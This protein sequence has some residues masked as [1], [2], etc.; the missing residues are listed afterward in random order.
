MRPGRLSRTLQGA[1]ACLIYGFLYIPLIVLMVY[2]F[3]KSKYVVFWRGFSFQ[4]YEKLLTN[5][6]LVSAAT[7]SVTIA[8]LS[9]TVATLIGT[10][11]AVA[12]HRFRFA[13]KKG[14]YGVLYIVMVSP[15]IVM[16]ISLLVL[17]SVLTIPLG[18]WTLLLSHITF[19]IP[20][21]TITVMSRLQGFDRHV[22]EAAMDLGASEYQIFRRIILPMAAPAVVAGWL[23]SF[24]LS[25]D[26]VIISFFTTGPTYEILPLR[27]YAMVRLGV[28]PEVNALCTVMIFITLLVVGLAQFLARDRRTA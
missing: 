27:I 1:Y 5:H 23:L 3:N 2:S 15:D 14:L 10:L 11:A 6:Q 28:K 20:F 4:W 16:G 13:G 7:H 21:V 17:F 25:L 8:L 22:V 19:C 26:D 24:T 12:L 18:F 9:A